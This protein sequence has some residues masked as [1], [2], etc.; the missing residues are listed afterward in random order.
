MPIA[1]KNGFAEGLAP[2]TD[3]ARLYPHRLKGEGHF[4]AL[5]RKKE[6]AEGKA[7]PAESGGW[8]KEM[9]AFGD[10]AK[11]V[12]QEKPKGIY[13]IYGEGL[14]LLPGRD[15]EAGKAARTADGMDAW[16]A[17]KGAV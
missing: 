8:T 14:Y 11:E 1:K 2:Y 6:A 9:D 15:T 16:N 10:F 3:C 5:L 4:L 17:E 7:I 12:L 13:K